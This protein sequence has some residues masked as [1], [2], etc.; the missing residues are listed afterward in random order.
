[1]GTGSNS[2]DPDPSF[3]KN[4]KYH[5]YKPKTNLWHRE[6]E[7]YNNHETQGRQTKQSNQL[8]LPH[9]D[10]FKTRMD[11]KPGLKA[12]PPEQPDTKIDSSLLV[13]NSLIQ[14]G[15][16][17]QAFV[18]PSVYLQIGYLFASFLFYLVNIWLNM[19]ST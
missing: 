12:P 17:F 5:N 19:V 18:R 9:H 14:I 16:T 1:M 6:E 7:P 4:S 11:I 8:P 13:S 3:V 15:L 10:D 2:L